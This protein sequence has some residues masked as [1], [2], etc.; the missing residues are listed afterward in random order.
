MRDIHFYIDTSALIKRYWSETGTDFMN[1]LYRLKQKDNINLYTAKHTISEFA[2]VAMRLMRENQ[3]T[4][5]EANGY[6]TT[7]LFESTNALSFINL[8]DSIFYR[9]I[10]M[11]RKHSLKAADA[12]HLSAAL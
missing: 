7:F 2:S 1:H 6:V 12:L 3:F 5:E 10:D 8:N 4:K 11:V 9:S